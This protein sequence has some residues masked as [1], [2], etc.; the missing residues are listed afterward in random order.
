M[1]RKPKPNFHGG[2]GYMQWAAGK[3]GVKA[4]CPP[5]VAKDRDGNTLLTWP[6][7]LFQYVCI[8]C[9]NAVQGP[10]SKEHVWPCG[11]GGQDD[12]VLENREVCE[13]CHR[14]LATV[15]QPFVERFESIRPLYV[16]RTRKGRF[17]R[18]AFG[19]VTIRRHEGGLHVD[20]A[21]SPLSDGERRKSRGRGYEAVAEG[22]DA[23]V[24][25]RFPV[26]VDMA[27]SRGLHKMA[28]GFFCW[29]YGRADALQPGLDEVR[30]YV[31]VG[32]TRFRPVLLFLPPAEAVISQMGTDPH[33]KI[34]VDEDENGQN[35]AIIVALCGRVYG[36]SLHSDH[37]AILR[38]G[39]HYV[40]EC[41]PGSCMWFDQH[42]RAFAP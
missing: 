29:K 28:L 5:T 9:K 20:L 16:H 31:L 27:V 38:L 37:E 6:P 4:I 42:G 12:L 3:Y 2:S 8:Y 34:A 21:G 23:K 18:S 30:R 26:R 14:R 22:G 35:R 13:I 7:G 25:F 33:R 19:D 36:I 15:D 39:R 10:E 17:P 1:S 41:G 40:K 32:D 11:L 24:R